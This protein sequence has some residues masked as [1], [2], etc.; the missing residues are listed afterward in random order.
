MGSSARTCEECF[1]A[2]RPGRSFPSRTY[3]QGYQEAPHRRRR[4]WNL[5][6]SRAD[7]TLLPSFPPKWVDSDEQEGTTKAHALAVLKADSF[8]KA[9]EETDNEQGLQ[10]MGQDGAYEFFNIEE[11]EGQED[12]SKTGYS[13]FVRV[14]IATSTTS[15]DDSHAGGREVIFRGFPGEHHLHTEEAPIPIHKLIMCVYSDSWTKNTEY[16]KLLDSLD[17]ETG[18]GRWPE[19]VGLVN[20]TVVVAHEDRPYRFIRATRGTSQTRVGKSLPGARL[21]WTFFSTERGSLS[22]HFR[23]NGTP[24]V[25]RC[26][27]GISQGM[28]TRSESSALGC[29]VVLPVVSLSF[30][31]DFDVSDIFAQIMEVDPELAEAIRSGNA[32]VT[33]GDYNVVIFQE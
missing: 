16:I 11:L 13:I 6:T 1:F 25:L 30:E 2:S 31:Q 24:H 9:C 15:N 29:R 22:A 20:I 26:E 18:L 23:L 12:F 10:E 3:E 21:L 19:F 4:K 27:L 7:T 33:T 14:S 28:V 17:P 32:V 8:A 5:E